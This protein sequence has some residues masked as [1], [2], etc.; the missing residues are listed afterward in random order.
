MKYC[1]NCGK[2]LEDDAKFCPSCGTDQNV[3]TLVNPIR[4]SN[5]INNNVKSNGKSNKSRI[6]G[7]ILAFFLGAFG[8]H[9]FYLGK[10]SS[11]VTQLLLTLVGWIVVIGPVVSCIWAF[12][13][14]IVILCGCA[15]DKDGLLVTSWGGTE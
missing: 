3:T 10:T 6:V 1:K 5:N 15:K 2:E 11:A 4:E 7:A 8:A 14:F 9:N 13:D 12:V